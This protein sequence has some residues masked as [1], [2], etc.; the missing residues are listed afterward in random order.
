M[1]W[2]CP[3]HHRLFPAKQ[4]QN[5]LPGIVS[6]DPE[7]TPT[8]TWAGGIEFRLSEAGSCRAAV[9]A[10]RAAGGQQEQGSEGSR[11]RAWKSRFLNVRE[12]EILRKPA[13]DRSVASSCLV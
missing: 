8:K 13:G 1:T 11:S 2:A 12:K 10:L 7:E 5:K 6:D 9:P 4:G 3:D